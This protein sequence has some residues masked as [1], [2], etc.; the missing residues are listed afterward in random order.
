MESTIV[1]CTHDRWP[2]LE[3]LFGARGACGG[4]WCMWH[5]LPRSDYEAGK[6]TTHRET[7]RRRVREDPPPGLLAYVGQ[8]P[9]GWCSVS[10]RTELLRL[11]RSRVMAPTAQGPPAWVVTCLFIR[12]S[13]RRSG[14]SVAL[15]REA[16]A[17][18]GRHGAPAVEAFPVV[19]RK[20]DLPPVFAAHGVL[21]AYLRSGFHLVGRRSEAR[22]AVRRETHA[23]GSDQ[24]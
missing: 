12:P 18:A 15:I 2:D 3:R 7:M 8:E 9:V 19:P 14:L 20:P 17:F 23:A 24:T 5:R 22:A 4:C 11:A 1:P 10:P 6:G 13:H 21:S 16:V